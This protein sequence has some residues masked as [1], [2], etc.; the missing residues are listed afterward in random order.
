MIEGTRAVL[1]QSGLEHAAWT[2]AIRYYA[3]AWNVMLPNCNV[4]VSAWS[5]R[6]G[7][8]FTGKI[9]PFGA[10]CGAIVHGPVKEKA[11][12]FDAAAQ[13]VVFSGWEMSPG[14]AHWDYR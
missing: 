8:E 14:Y 7:D 1:Q 13:D 9:V 12:R 2:E 5:A 6:F 10:V 3:T 11:R 4:G